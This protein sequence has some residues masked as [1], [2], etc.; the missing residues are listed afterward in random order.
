VIGVLGGGQLGQM[1]ALAGHR[2]GESFYFLD[3]APDAPAGK[4]GRH[5]VAEYDDRAALDELAAADLVTFE[6]ENV[7]ADSA[8]YLAQRTTV[9]PPP[10]ALEISQNRLEEK[11]WFEKLG[12]PTVRFA[13]ANTATELHTSLQE[14]GLPAVVKTASGGYDGKGQA[15]VSNAA[16]ADDVW[17]VLGGRQL[18]VEALVP[19]ERELSII[20]VRNVGGSH[21]LYPLVENRHTEGILRMSLAP[22]PELSPALQSQ[23]EAIASSLLDAL[24]YVGVLAIEL[25]QTTDGLLANELAPRVHNSGHYSIDGAV[26][27]QFENHIRAILNL[28]LGS[29]ASTGRAVM[30]NLISEL[31][32]VAEVL[33]VPGA[34]L[35]LYDKAPRPGRKLGHVTLVDASDHDLDRVRALLP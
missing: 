31:P 28:P 18:L 32:D 21:A 3:P 33:A 2:L 34:R 12:V 29:T 5:I 7:P 17:Q 16:A 6:F 27:S 10:T 24:D 25:F 26:C 19:F 13:P 1:L 20:G 15:V 4:L 22:A 14:V 11:R 35:H 9:Y 8:R 23:G 30:F